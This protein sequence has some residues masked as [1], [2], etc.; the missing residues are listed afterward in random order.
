VSRRGRAIRWMLVVLVPVG[1]A[2]LAGL[3]VLWPSSGASPAQR[4]AAGSITPGTSYPRATVVALREDPCTDAAGA[5]GSACAT[6]M[7]HVEDG[8]GAGQEVQVDLPPDAVASGVHLGTELVLSRVPSGAGPSYQFQDFARRIPMLVLAVA[9]VLVVGLVARWRG[10]AAIL[11]LGFAFLVL[12]GFMLPAL[13]AGESPTWVT[14]VGSTAIMFVVL[15]LA[16][17]FS[18]RTTTALLGTLFGLALVAVLGAVA[19]AAAH[20]TGFSSDETV[21]LLQFDPTL[22]FSGLVLAGIVVAGLG[23]LNDVTVTQASAVWELSEASPDLDRRALFTRG[24]AIGRDHIAST[25]YTIVFAY[26]GA[27][28]PLLLL[29]E[30]YQRPAGTVLTGTAVGEEI[31]R[32]L[33]GAIALVLA[34]PVTTAIAALLV[35]TSAG[36][37]VPNRR[38]RLAD[39]EAAAGRV[40]P[41]AYGPEDVEHTYVRTSPALP[42]VRPRPSRGRGEGDGRGSGEHR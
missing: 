13:L 3:V 29:F 21:Q 5:E 30:I 26:A 42:A 14:L 9:F 33:V 38:F 2:T 22:N 31:I 32:V 25:V 1:L 12:L 16:H 7:V 11:S 27:A 15:Y 6:A 4:A 23:V 36:A 8:A 17:G 37:P 19:V 34:V 40:Q 39:G 18:V 10:I 35:T 24:M 20:L 28:L 41:A